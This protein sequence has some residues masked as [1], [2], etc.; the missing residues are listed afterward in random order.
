MC[1]NAA[2]TV[3]VNHMKEEFRKYLH[4]HSEANI[5]D[6]RMNLKHSAFF[7]GIKRAGNGSMYPN[8]V[9]GFKEYIPGSLDTFPDTVNVNGVYNLTDPALPVAANH[10]WFYNYR[11]IIK[12]DEVVGDPD[13][14]L[15]DI[16]STVYE[17]TGIPKGIFILMGC[18]V[19]TDQEAMRQ[20]G[21]AM[22]IANAEYPTR[23]ETVTVEELM[24][25]APHEIP[26]ER[27]A[28]YMQH[29][30]PLSTD[31][32][33]NMVKSGLYTKNTSDWLEQ[34]MPTNHNTLRQ[35]LKNVKVNE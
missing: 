10:S 7:E 23:F 33:V 34:V 28:G 26:K 13:Y 4:M 2:T 19:N 3:R 9:Y 30:H 20:A 14:F 18:L 24:P 35:K 31:M 17:R 5:L 15:K 29:F 1:S 16:I 22:D 11:S 32:A 25:H 8:I 27:G 6:E 12:Q 21:V